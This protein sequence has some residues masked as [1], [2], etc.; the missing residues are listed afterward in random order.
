MRRAVVLFTVGLLVI[1][2]G[3]F[4]QAQRG[5]VS[6]TVT[7]AD[8]AVL[9]GASVSASSDQ[10]LT[11]RSSA[12]DGQGKATLVGLDPAGNYVVAVTLD[13]FAGARIE[14]VTVRAGQDTPMSVKLQLAEISEELIVTAESPLVDVTKTQAGQD[15]TLQLTESLPT[16]RSYQDFL[17]LVPGVQDALGTTDNPASRSGV[18]Y[19]DIDGSQGD[20]GRSTDNLYY[21]DGINVTDR[22]LGINGANLNTEII[23]EQSVIT[24]AI[25]AEFVGV[26]GLVSNVVT[27][28]GGNQFSGSINYYTQSDSFVESNKNFPDQSFSTFDAAATLGGPIWKDKAW[29]FASF[30][31]VEREE[32]VTDE[33]GNFLRPATRTQDQGF[34]K[35]TW[36]F[37]D[38]DVLT[39]IF[40]SDP[41]DRDASFAQDVPNTADTTGE[42]GGERYSLGYNRVWGSAALELAFTDHNQD[43]NTTPKDQSQA[44]SIAFAPGTTFTSGEERLG[45]GGTNFVEERAT[46]AARASLEYLFDTSWGDHALKFGAVD[47]ESSLFENDETSGNPPATFI[48]LDPRGTSGTIRL[49]EVVGTCAASP[50]STVDFGVSSDEVNGFNEGLTAGQRQTLLDLGWDTNGNGIFD[51]T[52]IQNNMTFSNTGGNP[53]G[54]INYTR[55]LQTQA[56]PSNKSSESLHYYIQDSWQHKKW[57]VNLGV[58]AEDTTFIDDLGNDV[59][60]W[61]NRGRA[62]C[63]G[64]LRHQ[65]RRSQLGRRVLR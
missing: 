36:A 57:S 39:G 46:E 34:G 13:G 19:R 45:G 52:E 40:L 38:S 58:R 60:T 6:V 1:S 7:D 47:A 53:Q 12:A 24:G 64:R 29:F 4:G 41:T 50:Y 37:T 15:I 61:D 22:T 23:Q 8:G 14:G 9:P 18:N 3:A 63:L 21:F 5:T 30:R 17:Q 32:D 28:S 35:L 31:Q 42:T 54:K 48:S 65:G 11:R 16:A 55:D 49:C 62:A 56:G 43:A 25:P 33:D 2:A 27:K 10:T 26:P 51:Q 20:V 59:G 44:N